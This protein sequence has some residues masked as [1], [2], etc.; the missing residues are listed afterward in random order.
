M[1]ERKK[2]IELKVRLSR[3]NLDFLERYAAA[4]HLTAAKIIDLS[5]SRLREEEAAE[6]PTA[7]RR[8]PTTAS[9]GQ[10]VTPRGG[11]GMRRRTPEH[12][13]LA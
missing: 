5:L 9:L 8:Q 7:S 11:G 13:P 4:R 1:G 3:E 12:R 2:K 6:A 10:R